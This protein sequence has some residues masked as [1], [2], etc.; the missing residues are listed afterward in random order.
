MP[1][2]LA[3]RPASR[4]DLDA[5][6]PLVQAYR[7]FYEQ[8][9]DAQREREYLAAHLRNGTSALYIAEVDSSAAGF[10]QLFPTF[11]TVHL[12]GSWILEDLFVDP[13]FRRRGV[14][15]ALLERA[16]E[17]VRENGG[18]GMFLETASD[19]VTAQRLYERAGWVREGRF[20][21]YNA[22]L[23]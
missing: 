22:P 19:N 5:L 12:A 17:H 18:C 11:S 10:M 7:V 1:A 21:K 4:S 16:L 3:I 13:R 8:Q 20:L 14:A 15:R 23:C 9:P 6:L 2:A